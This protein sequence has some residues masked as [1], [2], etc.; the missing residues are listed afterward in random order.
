MSRDT[1]RTA[2][3]LQVAGTVQGVGF[4]PFVARVAAAH[5]L[6]GSVRN[7]DDGVQVVFEGPPAAVDR[8]V[9]TVRED[10]PPLASITSAATRE[11]AP[12]GRTEFEIAASSADGERAT[13]VPPDTGLCADCRADVADPDSRYHDYWATACVNCGPR[14][15]ITESLPYDRERTTMAAFPLCDDCRTAYETQTDRRFHAQ[16][17]ACPAC[18]PTLSLVA[19]DDADGTVGSP[20][21]TPAS[22][23]TTTDTTVL[24]RLA[25]RLRAG[26]LV[27]IKGTGGSHAACL[28]SDAA[29]VER[30]RDRLGRPRKPF[31]VMAPSLASVRSF[32]DVSDAEADT[33]TD[34]R[35]PIVLVERTDDG[36]L[37][38]VAPGLHTVGVMLP[39]SGLHHRLFAR[40]DEPIVATSANLPGEP[41]A[42]TTDALVGL[43]AVDAVVTHDRPIHVRCDDSVIRHVDG[44]RTFLRRS[45]GWVPDP[46]PRPAG[47][48]EPV[49][50]VG[51]R[52]DTTIAVAAG[53]RIVVSQHV[54]RVENPAT[55]RFHRETVEH[56]T[57]LLDCDPSRVGH[58]AHPD[59]RTTKLASAYGTETVAVQHH[60]A[61]AASLLAE[62]GRGRAIVIAADG[63]GFGPDG[64]IRGG[65]VLDASRGHAER[66]GG[67]AP[68]RLPGGERAVRE[69][70]RLLPALLGE[71]GVDLLVERGEYDRTTAETIHQQADRGVNSPRTTSAG[72]VLDAASALLGV[73]TEREYRGQPAM[74][75]EAAGDGAEPLSLTPPIDWSGE[76]QLRAPELCRRLVAASETEI[77]ALDASERATLA[78]TAQATLA[79]GLARIAVSAADERDRNAVGLTGGVAYNDSVARRVREQVTEA[80]LT[81]LGHSAVPP[82]DAGIA[83]GQAVVAD[84]RRAE[85]RRSDE[86]TET[87]SSDGST[88]IRRS[89]EPTETRSSDGSTEIRRS[90]EP[91]ETR[92]SDGSTEIRRTDTPAGPGAADRSTETRSEHDE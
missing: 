39:A 25:D 53:D 41:T 18:G 77:T 43:D 10:P 40:L 27:G 83:Y 57:G 70:L 63:I 79:D 73:C 82:G 48:D 7:T 62:H 36:W 5:D 55:E 20:T 75:L 52:E 44:R 38:P 54:G 12:A 69:P 58:D 9:E 30:L 21:A 42:T 33:L 92:S 2:V 64:V 78:A 84:A 37:D 14:Y 1:A 72:R 13:L 23:E 81:F 88:E 66:V 11:R 51:P 90:D 91:T 32:A 67:V 86:P 6:A 89:D 85:T 17:V 65:E 4:R 74:E 26:Q 68:F 28:A 34:T 49:L 59:F 47:A 22:R 3:E 56:L 76:P 50:A 19:D 60:H 87:R 45:R 31:A 8:A 15:A 24:D 35:R 71:R 46:L 80:G 29:A 16:T 61:H